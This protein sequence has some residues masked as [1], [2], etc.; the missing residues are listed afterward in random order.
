MVVAALG[1]IAQEVLAEHSRHQHSPRHHS[2]QHQNSSPHPIQ[3]QHKHPH[4]HPHPH[5]HQFSRFATRIV[6]VPA[7]V[8]RYFYYSPAPVVV[9]PPAY[10][11]PP[12][13]VA[14]PTYVAPPAT[15]GTQDYAPGTSQYLFFCPDSRRYYPD[16]RECAS[17]W[18]AVVPGVPGPPN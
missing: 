1:L 18:L 6:V 13:F 7:I 16:V 14:P 17:G 8:P 12:A 5:R 4:S 10:V 2:V 11:P 9:V 3:R 15:E